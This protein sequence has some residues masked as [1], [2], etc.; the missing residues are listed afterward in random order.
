MSYQLEDIK[1]R[2]KKY[3]NIRLQVS[4]TAMFT[5]CNNIMSFH[6]KLAR[7]FI[8]TN[9]VLAKLLLTNSGRYASRE[10]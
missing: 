8:I 5:Q 7:N 4:F 9:A 1:I 3:K 2:C 10:V 6:Q